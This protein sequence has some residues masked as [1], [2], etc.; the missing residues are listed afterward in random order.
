ML[1]LVYLIDALLAPIGYLAVLASEVHQYAYLLAIAPGVLLGLIA[2]ERSDRIAHELA[3]E[4]AFRRSTRALDARAEDLR[5]QAGWLQRPE[6]RVGESGAALEDRG[7]LERILLATTIEA[8]QAD[9]GRLSA[10]DPDGALVARLEIGHE[11]PAL[12]A[13]EQS[14]GALCS[15]ALAIAVGHSHVLAVTR[16]VPFSAV[17][18]DLLEHLAAQAAVTLEN[19]RLEELMRRT[20]A[21][22]RAILEGVADAVAAEDPDGRLVYVNAAAAQLLD[23]AELGTWLGIP[24]ERLPGRRVLSGASAE[25][26]VVRH[27]G[28]ARWSRVKASPVLEDGGAR[29]AISVI[30]DITEIKQAEESQRFLAESSRAL[31]GSLELSETLPAVARLVAGTLADACTIELLDDGELRLVADAGRATAADAPLVVPIPLRDGVAG[32]ISLFG[33]RVDAAV[34]EDLALRAGAAIDNARLYRTRA[35]IAKTLQQSLLPPELPLIRRVETAAHFRPVGE[36]NEV[37]GDFYD[38]FSTGE[39]EWFAVMGDVCGKGA[40]AASVTALA[41]YTIRAAVPR[42]RSPAGIL[43]WLNDAMLRQRAGRFVTI[44]IARLQLE[45]DG[46]VTVTVA[47]GGHPIPRILRASGLV[48]PL[49]EPGTLLGVLRD[50]DLFDCPARLFAG[51][52]LVL[53]TDGLTE[54]NAPHVWTPEHLDEAVAAARRLDAQGIVDQLAARATAEAERP[55]RDDLA[56]LALRVQPVAVGVDDVRQVNV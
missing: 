46:T 15:G 49:G 52:A 11:D 7:E 19:L 31:A 22:L 17:E 56:L 2:R 54:L 36:G 18:R 45:F 3:L 32:Q 5:R 51:D 50:V 33:G 38:L 37:G 25:P 41:R 8:V 39:R 12:Q 28:E 10:L 1:A 34:A 35:A 13:A 21:E 24:A 16:A 29:L 55:P 40:E 30:E 47:C 26:L 27:P 20:E 6:R 42:H 44:A 43:R 53:Y 4:R 48:E 14:L 23:G 9:G